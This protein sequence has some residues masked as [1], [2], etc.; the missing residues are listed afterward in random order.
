MILPIQFGDLLIAKQWIREDQLQIVLAEQEKTQKDLGEILVSLGLMK[1]KDLFDCLAE[2]FGIPFVD[3]KTVSLKADFSEQLS[4]EE[5]YSLGA[6]LIKEEGDRWLVG[7]TDPLNLPVVDRLKSILKHPIALA[8]IK[9]EDLSLVQKTIYRHTKAI[10]QFARALSEELKTRER[11]FENEKLWS[12]IA[13]VNQLLEMIFEEAVELK[14]SDIHL[15]PHDKSSK[16][17]FR[18][19]GL[20]QDQLFQD[21]SVIPAIISRVKLMAGLNISEKRLPQDGRFEMEVSGQKFDVRVSTLPTHKGESLV[22]RL[23]SQS[24]QFTNIALLGMRGHVLERMSTLI[25][26]PH[27]MILVVGPT[28]SGKSTTLHAAIHEIQRPDLK[29]ITIEDPIEYF[30]P[31]GVQ[32]QANH[33]IGLDFLSILRG[34]LRH[35]PDVMLLGEMRDLETSRVAIQTALTGR[36]LFSTL[37]TNDTI[38]AV[39]RLMD[40]GVERYL[41]ASSL[42]AVLAQRLLRKICPD[43]KQSV[44]LTSQ[45]K[46]WLAHSKLPIQEGSFFQ[47]KGCHA[48]RHSGY[49]GRQAIFE[50][51]EFDE[52]LCETLREGNVALFHQKATIALQ[53]KKLLHEA[54]RLVEQGETSCE[55]MI[56]VISV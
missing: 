17:R 8:L 11:G 24:E 44:S 40:L 39:Y 19:D 53:G 51:L 29:M 23:L 38:S 43:C 25:R 46:V 49:R 30:L 56:R 12:S 13:P 32:I 26:K 7:L 15:E 42:H 50:L 37:H 41:I 54:Y 4:E 14:A 20:L 45:Q 55:E 9:A 5:S 48:C 33:K 34:V 1:E 28:G 52:T 18:I 47:G 35:D 27:G 31:W 3:L 36:L 21:Y 2:Q 10:H 22:M 6:L 16:L